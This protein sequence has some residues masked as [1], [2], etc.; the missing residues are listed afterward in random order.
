MK[1]AFSPWWQQRFGALLPL[2]HVLREGLPGRWLRIHSLPG[3]KR[4][5]ETEDEYRELLRRQTTVAAELLGLDSSCYVVTPSY[6]SSELDAVRP[7]DEFSVERMVCAMSGVT[8]PDPVVEFPTD[9]VWLWVTE[10]EWSPDSES[11]ALRRIADDELRALWCNRA[12]GEIFAPYDGGVDLIVASP[13][14]R[15]TLKG[16]YGDWLSARS[17]GL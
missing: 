2:G 4:Y 7:T 12:T 8:D 5:P 3:S 13:E 9:Q 6:E 10:C 14:R 16:R 17:D 1:T 15:E 11:T